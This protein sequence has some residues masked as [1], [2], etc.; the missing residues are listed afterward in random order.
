M[1]LTPEP[2]SSLQLYSHLQAPRG[3][4]RQLAGQQQQQQPVQQRSV[5]AVLSG[6]AWT[7]KPVSRAAA[8]DLRAQ[9][10]RLQADPGFRPVRFLSGCVCDVACRARANQPIIT[11]GSV[12]AMQADGWVARAEAPDT[13]ACKTV[14]AARALGESR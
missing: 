13:I 11:R 1:R 12:S 9:L 4:R 10:L 5:E 14:E 2:R 6:L 7:P 3:T 8:A